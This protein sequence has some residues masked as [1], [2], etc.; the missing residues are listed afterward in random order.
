MIQEN[1]DGTSGSGRSAGAVG[2]ED[3]DQHPPSTGTPQYQLV[4]GGQELGEAIRVSGSQIL[5]ATAGGVVLL[6]ALW[7]LVRGEPENAQAGV[8]TGI[9]NFSGS[10]ALLLVILGLAG[11]VFPFTPWWPGDES[12][13]QQEGP[14]EVA[15]PTLVGLPLPDA[16][17]EVGARGL[18]LHINDPVPACPS[19]QIEMV[20]E[21]NPPAREA[22]PEGST[23]AVTL[24]C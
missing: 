15:V 2:D 17:A 6:V 18:A 16:E 20:V 21:Q 14:G 8:Q 4:Y 3:L 12:G 1:H 9:V 5:V 10:P 11:I 7:L 19:G 23:I 24:G 13:G 22:T